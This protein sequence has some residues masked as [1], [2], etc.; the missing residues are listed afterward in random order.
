MFEFLVALAL[1]VWSFSANRKRHVVQRPR[2]IGPTV[3]SASKEELPPLKSVDFADGSFVVGMDVAPGVYIAPGVP[4]FP[5]TWALSRVVGGQ[6]RVVINQV[7][8]GPA[9]VVI[10]SA[11]SA[12]ASQ[13]SGG[14]RRLN[15]WNSTIV[16][17][18]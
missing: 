16:G 9:M 8:E 5:L 11:D 18:R 2:P 6:R 1:F 7:S 3:G 13:H 14:W 10:T 15:G 12:I 4:G 17:G